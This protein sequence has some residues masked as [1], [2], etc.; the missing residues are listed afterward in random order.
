MRTRT[1]F[2]ALA[3]L[4]GLNGFAQSANTPA[5]K[6]ETSADVTVNATAL[7]T[8]VPQFAITTTDGQTYYYNADDVK[9]VT[10][11]KANGKVEIQLK[12]DATDSYRA[13]A[14]NVRFVPVAS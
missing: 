12:N 13:S 14:S 4:A 5:V 11:D 3:L 10:I 7:N 8:A 6:A 9:E 1:I 2:A